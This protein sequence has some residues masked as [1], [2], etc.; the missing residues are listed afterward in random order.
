MTFRVLEPTPPPV[1]TKSGL[2]LA[3][4][5]GSLEGKTL[6]FVDAWGRHS[7][8]ADAMYPLMKDIRRRLTT[9][10]GIAEILW[11]PKQNI[12]T[13]LANEDLAELIRRANGAVVGEAI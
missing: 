12:A 9:E 5:L 11:F 4:R 1:G 8:S 2:Q 3:H 6:A 10:Y 7:S 13:P